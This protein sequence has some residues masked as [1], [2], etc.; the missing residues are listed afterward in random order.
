[1]ELNQTS[2]CYYDKRLGPHRRLH[3]KPRIRLYRIHFRTSDGWSAHS[4]RQP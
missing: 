3:L 1:M 4:V 2:I